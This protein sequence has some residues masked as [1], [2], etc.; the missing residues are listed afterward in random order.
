MDAHL[1]RAKIDFNSTLNMLATK[2]LND[3]Y[4]AFT[5][6]KTEKKGAQHN[7]YYVHFVTTTE[8]FLLQRAFRSESRYYI[9]K[10]S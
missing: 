8:R 9:Y 10:V 3:H 4:S 2:L 5:L 6:R 7:Y 1:R